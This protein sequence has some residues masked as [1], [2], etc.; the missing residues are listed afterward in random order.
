MRRFFL[1]CTVAL[2]TLSACETKEEPTLGSENTASLTLTSEPFLHHDLFGG[3]DVITYTLEN[4]DQSEGIEIKCDSDWV[5]TS[6]NPSE[7]SIDITVE[8]NN[9]TSDR[10][11]IIT[12]SYAKQNFN[13][14]VT[15]EAGYTPTVTFEATYLN[16][17]YYGVVDGS[18]FNYFAILSDTGV[19]S[20]SSTTPNSKM[21]RFDIYSD[22]FGG[23]AAVSL[24][25]GV[26]KYDGSSSGFA[27]SFGDAFSSYIETGSTSGSITEIRII[28]GIVKV[29]NGT[30]NA[31]VKLQN[32]ETHRLT[33]TGN[34]E[35]GYIGMPK[36]PFS[37]LTKDLAFEYNSGV[38]FQAY[39]HGDRYGMGL[40][41]WAILMIQTKTPYQGDFF[42]I[43]LLAPI[44]N[45]DESSIYGEYV[46]WEKDLENYERTFIPGYYS[47][48][49]GQ[50]SYYTTCVNGQITMQPFAPI[51]GGTVKVSKS[52]GNGIKVTIDCVDDKGNKLQGSYTGNGID[53]YD[54]SK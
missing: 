9:T 37:T 17:S 33:Y 51:A 43:S 47:E 54:F 13:V 3:S 50:H 4:S 48:G 21:Y 44:S 53:I 45:M 5:K 30:I 35:L 28:S 27:G 26:F 23:F 39:Y 1:M 40:D 24:P 16:G 8:F 20:S 2:L 12:V 6:H 36:S 7:S 41:N 22:V 46:L 49:M 19:S 14:V 25:N 31:I 52:G 10:S 42:I 32:G 34:L 38:G 15:Q 29:D 11:A 18:D